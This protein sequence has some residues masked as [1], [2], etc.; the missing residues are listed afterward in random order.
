MALTDISGIGSKTAEKLKEEGITT[1][2][3]L[4]EAYKR[5]DRAVTGGPF[6]DGLNS[7]A[8]DG[9]RDA[10]AAQGDSFVDPVYGIPVTE[11]NQ[12]A[13]EA[14]D[15]E[16]GSDVASG[17]GQFTRDKGGIDAG[18][19]VLE[20]AGEA[21]E[22]NLGSLFQPPEYDELKPEKYPNIDDSRRE[23]L[24]EADEGMRA[25][26]E[27]FEFGLDAAANLAPF[28]RETLE[29]GN[30]LARQT[31]GMGAFTVSQTETVERGTQEGV[32]EAEDNIGIGS[33]N[34]ARARK[35]HMQRSERARDVDNQRK[36]EVTSD[37]EEWRSDPSRHDYP[38]IDT[39]GGRQD[40]VTEDQREQAQQIDEVV[41]GA[42]EEVTEIAFGDP[43]E[44]L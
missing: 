30:E 33:R 18:M 20:A 1:K 16:L 35:Y 23:G 7:R 32:I 27:G 2:Q 36:A 34:Y 3:E 28:D 39:P 24:E 17:F 19:N 38:G 25:R 6:D 12:Q 43:F 44:R 5:N 41:A 37:Y 13:R 29:S 22:G 10:L 40:I 9:I 21:I 26:K 42:G 15:L 31:A 14:F 8:L 11:E 4:F